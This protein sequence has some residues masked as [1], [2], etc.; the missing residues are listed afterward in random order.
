MVSSLAVKR[1]KK[2]KGGKM[3]VIIST[4]TQAIFCVS[5]A[6]SRR[7]ARPPS[8]PPP[9][10]VLKLWHKIVCGDII[11]ARN[12]KFGAMV[13]FKICTFYEWFL[14][15]YKGE[16]SGKCSKNVPNYNIYK[17]VKDWNLKFNMA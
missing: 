7:D 8:L 6:T 9:K 16:M 1:K 10:K 14:T 11:W 3:L 15:N 17:I 2:K 13:A 12:L 4:P 5:K